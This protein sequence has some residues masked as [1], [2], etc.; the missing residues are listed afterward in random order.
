[1]ST[2][3]PAL[4]QATSGLPDRIEVAWWSDYLALTKPRILV[5]ILLTVVMGLLGYAHRSL[6][7]WT[8]LHAL[9]GTSLIAAG[10]SILNQ[11][12]EQ[13]LDSLM[14]RTRSRPLPSG[15]LT[16]FEVAV[17]GWTTGIVGF[18]YL[19]IFT[20]WPATIVGFAT[21]L[22]YIWIYTPLKTR[23]WLNTV[24]G[25]LPG[26]LPVLIGWCAAGGEWWALQGWLLT[27]IVILWQFPHFMAIAWLYRNEYDAA[28]Y[29]MITN[30]ERTGLAASWL[31]VVPAVALLP[32]FY[33]SILPATIPEWLIAFIG[34]AAGLFQVRAA[35]RF[36]AHRDDTTARKLLYASLI[37]LP[38]V[39]VL[40]MIAACMH[41]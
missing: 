37:Y 31:A 6:S 8:T 36:F 26:A 41:V 40:V 29:K 35:V 12:L 10:A 19:I 39:M 5:M 9:V 13:D 28:G 4:A 32:V 3:H 21:W 38:A 27:G 20:N 23:T 22:T 25:T 34:M 16:S 33:F 14:H 2:S 7:I 15:R 1:M 24:V 18:A 17:F 30:V 11:W